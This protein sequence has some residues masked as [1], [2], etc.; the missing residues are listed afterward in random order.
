MDFYNCIAIQLVLLLVSFFTKVFHLIIQN[1]ISKSWGSPLSPFLAQ[2]EANI[3][4]LAPSRKKDSGLFQ[5]DVTPI[6]DLMASIRNDRHL[7]TYRKKF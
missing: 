5:I 2:F 4:N 1:S 7:T 6:A 3:R